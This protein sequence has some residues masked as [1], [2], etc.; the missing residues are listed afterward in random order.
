MP[1]M[2]R[3]ATGQEPPAQRV[4]RYREPGRRMLTSNLTLND[5]AA[6]LVL[7]ARRYRVRR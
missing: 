7:R 3:H 4:T 6:W 2:V 1:R 5:P